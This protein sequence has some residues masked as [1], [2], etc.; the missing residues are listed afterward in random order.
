MG[1]VI[2]PVLIIAVFVDIVVTVVVAIAIAVAPSIPSLV[3]SFLF[4]GAT[5][6]VK[7]ALWSFAGFGLH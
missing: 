1:F 5:N 3:H 4:F 6:V 2:S 7:F